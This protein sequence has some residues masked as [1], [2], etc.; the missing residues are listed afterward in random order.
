MKTR[1]N[2][3]IG[4]IILM[5]TTMNAQELQQAKV[6]GISTMSTYSERIGTYDGNVE[7][8][9]GTRLRQVYRLE[10]SNTVLEVTGYENIFAAAKRP[11]M[12]IGDEITYQVEKKHGQYIDILL[13][14][15]NKKPKWHRFLRISAEAK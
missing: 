4:F 1:F 12:Q 3:F 14:E 8:S 13:A 9:G 11:A 6:V 5:S 7:G 10:S 2:L 15:G